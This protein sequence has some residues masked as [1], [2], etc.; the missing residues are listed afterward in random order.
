MHVEL[1]T[2]KHVYF[3][4]PS[5]FDILM[6]VISQIYVEEAKYFIIKLDVY[7]GSLKVCNN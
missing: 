2:K 5:F 6:D 7:F 4:K 3:T 1:Q